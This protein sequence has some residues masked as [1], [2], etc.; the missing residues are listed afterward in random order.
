[1]GVLSREEV[2]KAIESKEIAIT[3]YNPKNL[4]PASLDLTLSSEFRLYKPGMGV[5]DI[6]DDTD[7]K[8]FTTL[9]TVQTGK[10]FLLP[11]GQL[12]CFF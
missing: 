1:M 12:S 6:H 10:G 9:H 11:P 3:P 7:Y 5:I 8:E 4:G 2:L